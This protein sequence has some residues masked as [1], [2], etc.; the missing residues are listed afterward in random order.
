MLIT[1]DTLLL[2][3]SGAVLFCTGIAGKLNFLR[4]K[5]DILRHYVRMYVTLDNPASDFCPPEVS[6][7]TSGWTK[8][9][10]EKAYEYSL[11]NTLRHVTDKVKEVGRMTVM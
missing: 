11:G 8:V 6:V 10:V 5:L 2:Y 3:S 1:P 7:V 9:A 4:T